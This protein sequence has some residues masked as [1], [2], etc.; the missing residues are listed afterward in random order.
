MGVERFRASEVARAT[1][2]PYQTLVM[3]DR[4]GLFGPAE[5]IPRGSYKE[6]RYSMSE[7]YALAVMDTLRKIGFGREI[8]VQV[9]RLIARNDSDS[10]AHVHVICEDID[11]ETLAYHL[12]D[13]RGPEYEEILEREPVFNLS[14]AQHVE[15]TRA[16]LKELGYDVPPRRQGELNLN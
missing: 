3:W 9:G 13:D 11:P 2:I 7:L 1:G 8:L 16:K 4:N 5:R 12:V 14:L 10:M 6:R 15:N